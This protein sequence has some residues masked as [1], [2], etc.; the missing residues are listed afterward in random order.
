LIPISISSSNDVVFDLREPASPLMTNNGGKVMDGR[1]VVGN[2][3]KI[4]RTYLL[5][6]L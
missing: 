2:I 6:V 5:F 1:R 3:T 4:R